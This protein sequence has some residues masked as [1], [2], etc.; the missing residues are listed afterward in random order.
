M[1]LCNAYTIALADS[2]PDLHCLLVQAGLN[3]PDGK[4]VVWANRL[5]HRGLGLGS[6][7]VYGPDLML[8][9]FDRGRRQRLKHYL[10][11][12]TE[13]VLEDLERALHR[14]FP[15]ADI[16]GSES[17]PFRR[18]THD[19]RTAQ[20]RRITESGA[21]LVWVGLG[22]PKQDFEVA[23]L[24]T[25]VPAVAVAVGAAFDFLAG[26]KRQAPPWLGRI[27]LEWAHRLAQEP[28]RLW[29]RYAFGNARFLWAVARSG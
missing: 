21:G 20:A 6:Q 9:V 18:L 25:E 29:R 12:S 22:T 8:D 27:G 4:S 19:E 5:R 11:G 3:F 23:A 10:L 7:R 1:H 13:P 14:L 26:T 2:D 17:P 28:R 15:S 24:T 16:V